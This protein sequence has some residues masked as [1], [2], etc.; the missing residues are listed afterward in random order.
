ML[1]IIS[2]AEGKRYVP[3]YSAKSSF[4]NYFP[5]WFE[6]NGRIN[7][8][9]VILHISLSGA[10]YLFAQQFFYAEKARFHGHYDVM[11]EIQNDDCPFRVHSLGSQLADSEA[12]R[13]KMF[14]VCLLLIS[15]S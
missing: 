8:F 1:H 6:V 11:R 12:W 5:E 3:F 9:A 15:F 4:C 13:S 2:G 7:H 14:A 10:Y